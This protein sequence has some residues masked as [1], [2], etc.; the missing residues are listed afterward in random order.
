MQIDR[1]ELDTKLDII[2]EVIRKSR[3]NANDALKLCQDLDFWLNK[4]ELAYNKSLK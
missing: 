2:R 3:D 4:T 1:N